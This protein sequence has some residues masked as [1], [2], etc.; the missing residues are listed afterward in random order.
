MSQ[1]QESPQILRAYRPRDRTPAY[2]WIG[3][4]VGMG[5]AIFLVYPLILLIHG[6]YEH[7][8]AGASFKAL[9]LVIRGFSP[10]A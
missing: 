10:R 9:K 2:P 1:E 7:L 8:F 4:L 3:L 6:L 5:I